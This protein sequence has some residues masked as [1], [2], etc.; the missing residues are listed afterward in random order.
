MQKYQNHI[1]SPI[2]YYQNLYGADV[3]IDEKNALQ[4]YKDGNL[5]V[6]DN[7]KVKHQRRCHIYI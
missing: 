7:K 4:L 6:A 2:G 5:L 1:C 3:D